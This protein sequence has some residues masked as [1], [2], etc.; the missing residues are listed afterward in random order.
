MIN[1][2]CARR[3]GMLRR[4]SLNKTGLRRAKNAR[5]SKKTKRAA[6]TPTVRP[7]IGTPNRFSIER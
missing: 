1:T 2:V 3:L 5:T 4:P 7:P 6:T